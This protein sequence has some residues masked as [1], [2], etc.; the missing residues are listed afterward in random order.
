MLLSWM[1]AALLAAAP[2]DVLV[3]VDDLPLASRAIHQDPRERIRIVRGLLQVLDRHHVRAVGFVKG[4]AVLWGLEPTVLG[5]SEPG[6]I[7]GAGVS[8]RWTLT[9]TGGGSASGSTLLLLHHG[10]DGW[11]IVQDASM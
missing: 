3:T 1:L 8:A 11:R 4:N 5:E 6:G 10:P 2:R 9:G 7:H